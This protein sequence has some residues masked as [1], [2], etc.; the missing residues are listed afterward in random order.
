VKKTT[1]LGI[2]F[3][4]LVLGYLVI[5]SFQRQA[6]R[7]QICITFKGRRDCGT[8]RRKASKKPAAPPPPSPAPRLRAANHRM[9]I[10]AKIPRPIRCNGF[11]GAND[12]GFPP[13]W[14]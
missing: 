1:W 11:P 9:R 7:C 5:S 6:Y 12:N 8:A 14:F 2:L 3:A 10:N 4:V 13:S